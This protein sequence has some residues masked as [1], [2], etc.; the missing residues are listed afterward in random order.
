MDANVL[1][2]INEKL[3]EKTGKAAD[4]YSDYRKVWS[5]MTSTRS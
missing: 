2:A 1:G 4:G 5:G 3:K